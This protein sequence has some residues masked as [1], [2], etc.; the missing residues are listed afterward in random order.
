MIS[1]RPFSL[2]SHPFRTVRSNDATRGRCHSSL[3]LPQ[4]LQSANSWKIHIQQRGSD[5]LFSPMRGP[6][7]L[8]RPRRPRTQKCL[9]RAAC[10]TRS[11]CISQNQIIAKLVFSLP[12]SLEP[13]T[14]NPLAS[15]VP[16]KDEVPSPNAQVPSPKY[17][18]R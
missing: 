7:R 18:S 2:Y 11:L 4:E 5:G 6:P 17:Q 8:N 9:E 16:V 15:C 10:V 14:G 12:I 13:L 1:A 3:Q